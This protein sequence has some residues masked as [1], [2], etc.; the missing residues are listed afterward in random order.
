MPPSWRLGEHRGPTGRS[1][2]SIVGLLGF[3]TVVLLAMLLL[4]SYL[5]WRMVRSTTVP[6]RTRRRLTRLTVALALL[7]V[8]A[9]LLR[10]TLP[11]E[12]AALLDWV[13]YSWL[14]IAFYAFLALL[15][16]EPIRL[17]ALWLREQERAADVVPSGAKG[18]AEPRRGSGTTGRAWMGAGPT[19]VV[20]SGARRAPRRH[21]EAAQR[22][23]GRLLAAVRSGRIAMS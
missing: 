14:G 8:L 16:L 18:S 10:R 23:E 6:G 12:V 5:W 15:A 2:L 22:D 20:L 21:D 19:D 3:G 11:L 17:V 1:A 7:P 9:I 4:H 13:A